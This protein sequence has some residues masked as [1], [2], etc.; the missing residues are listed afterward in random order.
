MAVMVTGSWSQQ[1]QQKYLTYF[2]LSSMFKQH[3]QEQYKTQTDKTF[4]HTRQTQFSN[5]TDNN[6]PLEID[7][8]F[9]L[10]TTKQAGSLFALEGRL[11]G[12]H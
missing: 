9:Q 10:I 12:F 8:T 3:L 7:K 6:F 2:C 5:R 11:S 1:R 4:Q